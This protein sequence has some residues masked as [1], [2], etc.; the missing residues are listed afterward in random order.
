M[1][2]RKFQ[3]RRTDSDEEKENVFICLGGD[4]S[5]TRAVAFSVV[6]NR[7]VRDDPDSLAVLLVAGRLPA[8]SQNRPAEM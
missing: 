1:V 8:I 6:Q 2:D 7:E 4:S 3:Q 5:S